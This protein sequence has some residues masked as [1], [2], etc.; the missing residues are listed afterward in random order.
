MK[1]WLYLAAAIL[2]E[3]TGTL[4]LKAAL[5]QPLFY[6]LVTLGYI[7]AFA[8]L[9]VSLRNGMSL[10]V[11][12]G[13]WGAGG[14]ALTAVMSLLIFGEPITVIM[15]LGLVLVI[16]GVLLVEVGAH[17]AHKPAHQAPEAAR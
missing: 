9:F 1:K 16:A 7:G 10:G 6:A 11:G 13:I 15:G 4:A 3:V 5:E 12:Y 2:S 17:A 14:V 8:G